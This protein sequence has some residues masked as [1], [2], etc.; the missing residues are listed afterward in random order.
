M[1]LDLA[2]QRIAAPH[3]CITMT[4]KGYESVN[5]GHQV[6]DLESMM[7]ASIRCKMLTHYYLKVLIVM[8][9]SDEVWFFWWTKNPGTPIA[10]QH[11]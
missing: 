11:Y 2:D 5:Q 10:L 9:C 6:I 7:Y 4:P 8:A 1:A 3:L